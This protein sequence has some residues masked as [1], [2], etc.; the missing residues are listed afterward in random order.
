MRRLLKLAI[1]S[2]IK[3][4]TC[5]DANNIT[6]YMLLDTSTSQSRTAGTGTAGTTGTAGS[7]NWSNPLTRDAVERVLG[8]KVLSWPHQY[9]TAFTHKSAIGYP[10]ASAESFEVLEFLGDSVLNFVV[11]KYL[12]DTYKN[13]NEGFLTQLRTKLVSGKTL[14]T[15]AQQL[16]L[17]HL[18]IMSAKAYKSS[19]NTNPRIL[20]DVLEA[21]IGAVYLD[22]GLVAA[23]EFIINF[24]NVH[25]TPDML[26]HTNFKDSIMQYAQGHDAPLPVYSSTPAE[27]GGFHIV[28]SVCGVEGHGYGRTKREGEQEA[29]QDALQRLRA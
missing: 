3:P 16:G 18:V 12:F 5:N 26:R 8:A 21:L 15:I 17:Q 10:G 19:F 11:G 4:R 27:H 9:V 6:V 14:A 28:V 29:A 22:M 2:A 1:T 24:L 7:Q 13:T 23:R 20:E 25:I